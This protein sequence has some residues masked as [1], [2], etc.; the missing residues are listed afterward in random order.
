MQEFVT[1]ESS[2]P[3]IYQGNDYPLLTCEISY[4]INSKHRLN[5]L[6]ARTTI[7]KGKEKIISDFLK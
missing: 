6:A 7:P 1:L 4:P 2:A 5:T 3:T